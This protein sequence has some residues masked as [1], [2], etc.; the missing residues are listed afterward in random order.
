M[1]WSPGDAAKPI[2]AAIRREIL[3]TP[4]IDGTWVDFA[5]TG[6]PYGTAMALLLLE[7]TR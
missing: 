2:L 4:E 1:T 6:K 3:A 7:M 5:Q